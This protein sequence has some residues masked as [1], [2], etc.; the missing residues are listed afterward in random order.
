M[1]CS[2]NP[3]GSTNDNYRNQSSISSV[4]AQAGR[5]DAN[6]NMGSSVNLPV[7]QP[8]VT[9][10]ETP[11][12]QTTEHHILS[13]IPNYSRAGPAPQTVSNQYAYEQS[14]SQNQEASRVPNFMVCH[15]GLFILLFHAVKNVDTGRLQFISHLLKCSLMQILVRIQTTL[16]QFFVQ[17]L[18]WMHD[19]HSMYLQTLATSIIQELT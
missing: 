15:C 17:V 13:G 8:E 5:E 14:E 2:V 12:Q 3:S 11:G 1:G 10:T 4:D 16:V 6:V 18:I 19:I 7:S 9:K